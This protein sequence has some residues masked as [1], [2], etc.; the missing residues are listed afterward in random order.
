MLTLLGIAL[1]VYT[2]GLVLGLVVGIPVG[3]RWDRWRARILLWLEDRRFS[4][5]VDRWIR[6]L[7][8]EQQEFR[9][10]E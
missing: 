9:V 1:A 2:A 10:I 8:A 5:D 4:R 7:E 3:K 6:E